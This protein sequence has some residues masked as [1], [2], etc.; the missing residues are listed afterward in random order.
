MIGNIVVIILLIVAVGAACRFIW[1]SKK[2][3]NKCIGCSAS[4]TSACTGCRK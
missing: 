1:K 3:G 4:G 2:N